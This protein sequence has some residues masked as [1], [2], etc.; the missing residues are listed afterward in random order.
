MGNLGGIVYALVFRFQPVPVGKAFWIAG[1][2]AMVCSTRFPR[3]NCLLMLASLGNQPTDLRHSRA[4]DLIRSYVLL[5]FW[6]RLRS[7]WPG[8]T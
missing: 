5:L 4:T 8:K 2:I 6:S 1:I 3:Q 7:F